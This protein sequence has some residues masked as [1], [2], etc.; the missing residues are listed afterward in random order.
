M[1]T[2]AT[3]SPVRSAIILALGFLLPLLVT[4]YYDRLSAAFTTSRF[5]STS[6]YTPRVFNTES[7]NSSILARQQSV[8]AIVLK[9]GYSDLY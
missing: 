4:F 5:A 6:P 9:R 8:G 1:A 3:Y 2:A 7:Q